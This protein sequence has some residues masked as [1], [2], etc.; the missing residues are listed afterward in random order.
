MKSQAGID[1]HTR[2]AAEVSISGYA[3][4]ISTVKALKDPWFTFDALLVVLM[5]FETWVAQLK[6]LGSSSLRGSSSQ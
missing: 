3:T 1:S 4:Y 5:N 2:I 6:S